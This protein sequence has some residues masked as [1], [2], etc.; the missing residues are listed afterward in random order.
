MTTRGLQYIVDHAAAIEI[1]R[2]RTVAQMFT[3]SGRVR[4]AERTSLQPYVIKVTPPAAARY[5]DVRDV[6]EGITITDRANPVWI[7]L[8]N[9]SGMDY[10]TDYKG[11]LTSTQI[12]ALRVTSTGTTAT[13]FGNSTFDTTDVFGFTTSTNFDYVRLGNLPAIGAADGK[14]GTISST[15]TM[16]KSGDYLQLRTLSSGAVAWGI[17]RTVPVDVQRGSLAYV[18]VP[19][20]RRWINIA[21]GADRRGADLYFGNEVRFRVL[22]TSMPNFKLRPGKIVE[23][24]GDFELV[25]DIS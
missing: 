6:I 22:I 23:W 20:H 11:D 15:S 17:L 25:E 1:S 10:I 12:D 19:V 13:I 9:T 24:T 4:T 16:F 18:D 21:T 7:M 14:G 2:K 8:S 5:E 3:R